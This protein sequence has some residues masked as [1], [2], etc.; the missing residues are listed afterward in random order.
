M[1]RTIADILKRALKRVRN[2]KRW[3]QGVIAEDEDGRW[4]NP[5]S[6]RAVRWCASGAIRAEGN[7]LLTARAEAL[8]DSVAKSMYK[9]LDIVAVNDTLGHEA[10]LKVYKEAIKRAR[11]NK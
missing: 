10:I 4:I 2:K 6:K 5:R 8:L 1:E 7:S 9:L 3:T 11:G